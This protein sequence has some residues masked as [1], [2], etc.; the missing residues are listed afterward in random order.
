MDSHV[1][2]NRRYWNE[3]AE[4][5]AQ[6]AES[7]WS[8]V[9]HWGLWRVPDSEV[10]LLPDADGADVIE[11]GCG[12][13]YVGG[14]LASR[15]A[16]VTGIDNSP[17]QLA[18]D[19]MVAER[20]G[21]EICTVQGDMADLSCFDAARF[22]FIFHPCSNGFVPA[23]RPVWCEA[24]RILRPGGDL[25]S[26]FCNP[27]LYIF[28]DE[29]RE[30]GELVVRHQIPYSDLTSLSEEE[31]ARYA[32]MGDPASFGHSLDDQLG[33]QIAAGFAITGFYEDDWG[34]GS[35]EVLSR[36][37]KP[38]IATKATKPA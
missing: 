23:V 5:Y 17:E 8:A 1:A 30:R 24:Y 38:F 19:R 26:G 34:P 2:A 22:D 36:Y 13:A 7:N 18:Q 28:D 31:F 14:W 3:Q 35:D 11:L 32:K 37:I 20:E 27:L 6:A 33:G 10:S 4:W 25:I 12:T 9:P 16:N 15:G 29:K 21:L